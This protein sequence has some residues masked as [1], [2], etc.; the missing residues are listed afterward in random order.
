MF[1]W[2]VCPTGKLLFFAGGGHGGVLAT[3]NGNGLFLGGGDGD[4]GWVMGIGGCGVAGSKFALGGELDGAELLTT[5]LD[6]VGGAVGVATLG[7]GEVSD[8]IDGG[9]V[10]VATGFLTAVFEGLI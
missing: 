9:A 5:A 4:H 3:A 8:G 7:V 6:V 10:D 1:F 2:W